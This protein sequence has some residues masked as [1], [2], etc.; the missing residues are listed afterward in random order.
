[1]PTMPA[2]QTARMKR[3]QHLWKAVS[4]LQHRPLKQW[5]TGKREQV[6]FRACN[7]ES[8]E[9]IVVEVKGKN[10]LTALSWEQLFVVKVQKTPLE[11]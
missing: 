8:S 1:M 2:E 4:F 9:S 7:L 3:F 10:Q 5:P 11:V 6:A